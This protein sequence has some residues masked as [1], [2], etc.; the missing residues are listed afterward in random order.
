MADAVLV[1]FDGSPQSWNALDTAIELHPSAT[2]TLLTVIDPIEAGS[3]HK[4]VVPGSGGEWFDAE[5]AAA[6][7]R[8]QEAE[9]KV[10]SG[11]RLE[12]AIRVGRPARVII[13]HAED[14][15]TDAI[16]I[17]SHGRSGIT[18]ILLGSVAET[19]VRR[20]PVPVTIVR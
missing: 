1:P 3:S 2:I 14:T 9:T 19:V 17:G 6:Q 7:E 4:T 10:P 18:R 20:S 11:V 12:T 15:E 5:Q 8:F 16:V 13:E